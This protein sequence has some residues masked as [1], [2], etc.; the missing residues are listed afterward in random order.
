MKLLPTRLTNP[1]R[2]RWLAWRGRRPYVRRWAE[3]P[4]L[5][6][7]G[8]L[9]PVATKVGAW[10]AEVVPPLTRPGER[11]V[12]MGC[13]TGI[14]GLAL[15]GRGVEA[16][17]VDV[18]PQAVRNARVNGELRGTPLPAVESDLF[19]GVPGRWDG[20]VYNVPFWPGEPGA[21]RFD[22]SF[23]AGE[24]FRAIR[25][26]AAEAPARARRVL[27][28]LSQAGA[29][30]ARAREAFGPAEARATA[31]VGGETLVLLERLPTASVR[32]VS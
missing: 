31:L 12:D 29:D 28:A 3:G 11:W 21:G 15:V 32:S 27:V 7:P 23:F 22:R 24:D 1:V 25:R 10:L 13:G 14:V 2:A 19:E 4:L 16:L 6:L 18:D 20:V 17:A 9:D 5:V 30:H 26:Y 8:V